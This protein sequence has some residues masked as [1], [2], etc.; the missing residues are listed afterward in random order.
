MKII[1]VANP[2]S[3]SRF[4]YFSALRGA[5]DSKFTAISTF[6]GIT[7][8]RPLVAVLLVYVFHIGLIG[9]W[10]ALVS[11]A[12]LCYFLALWRW[13]SEKWAHIVV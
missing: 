12:L 5:G 4:L 1:A 9:V 11:D 8:V 10:I 13:R 3:N 2:M 6:L 7:F